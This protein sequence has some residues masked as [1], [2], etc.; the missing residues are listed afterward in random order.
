MNMDDDG[1]RLKEKDERVGRDSISK[2]FAVER[3]NPT[4][5]RDLNIVDLQAR[6]LQRRHQRDRQTNRIL[7][8]TVHCKYTAQYR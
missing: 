4:L 1:R 5:S 3:I 6:K 8:C 2:V 7:Y